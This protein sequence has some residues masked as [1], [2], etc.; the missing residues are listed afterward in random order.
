MCNRSI[1]LTHWAQSVVPSCQT[2]HLLLVPS[3]FVV[4]STSGRICRGPSPRGRSNSSPVEKGR[5]LM[6]GNALH[7]MAHTWLAA[8]GSNNGNVF[9]PS[10]SRQSTTHTPSP[11]FCRHPD[12]ESEE[13]A[14]AREEEKRGERRGERGTA[15][16]AGGALC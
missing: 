10:S 5:D 8:H 15:C 4:M 2:L 13:R 11:C 12:A 9:A 7:S 16:L 14:R 1:V 3:R 6:L